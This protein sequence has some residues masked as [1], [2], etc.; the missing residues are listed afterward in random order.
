M[1]LTILKHNTAAQVK[2][3]TR[4]KGTMSDIG[5]DGNVYQILCLS[6]V[7]QGGPGRQCVRVGAV[8]FRVGKVKITVLDTS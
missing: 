6:Q 1:S 8:F 2:T 7:R 3:L 4:Q 5:R